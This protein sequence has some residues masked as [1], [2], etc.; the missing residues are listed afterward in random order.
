[1][2]ELVV[3]R[4]VVEV[5]YIPKVWSSKVF[6]DELEKGV[7]RGYADGKDEIQ[8][9]DFNGNMGWFLLKSIPIDT[10]LEGFKAIF[11]VE[12][13]EKMTMTRGLVSLE[14]VVI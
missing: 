14:R 9:S 6:F 8:L 11:S 2:T 4:I 13:Y 3:K 7:I 12:L 1:M 5:Q 10:P